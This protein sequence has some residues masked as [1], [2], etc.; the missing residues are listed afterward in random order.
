ML[1]CRL[2][3]LSLA[4]VELTDDIAR[5]AM[6][7]LQQVHLQGVLHGDVHLSNFILVQPGA[8]SGMAAPA[9]AAPA[10]AAERAAQDAAAAAAVEPHVFVLDFGLARSRASEADLQ[11]EVEELAAVFACKVGCTPDCWRR[12]QT[13]EELCMLLTVGRQGCCALSIT[14]HYGGAN[15]ACAEGAATAMNFLD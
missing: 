9:E 14:G 15:H 4:R 1:L 2:P 7:A 11:A 12:H 6:A 10:A 13:A 3:G 8:A 5:L